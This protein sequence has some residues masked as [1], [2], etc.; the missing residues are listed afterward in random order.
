MLPDIFKHY[1]GFRARVRDI[2]SVDAISCGLFDHVL[3]KPGYRELIVEL[4]LVPGPPPV[5]REGLLFCE[6]WKIEK[7]KQRVEQKKRIREIYLRNRSRSR[8]KYDALFKQFEL[9]L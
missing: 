2:A 1:P 3:L 8:Y 9:P 7:E 4:A 5:R 6:R